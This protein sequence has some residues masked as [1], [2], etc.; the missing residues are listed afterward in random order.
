VAL[1]PVGRKITV[2]AI[3]AILN[4][5]F[6]TI[7]SDLHLLVHQLRLP[8]KRKHQGYLLTE[9]IRLCKNCARLGEQLRQ[10]QKIHRLAG[11]ADWDPFCFAGSGEMPAGRPTE[12]WDQNSSPPPS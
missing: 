5:R 7:S 8:I 12:G 4:E 1:L 9:P 3:S 2:P 11:T 6:S 10:V